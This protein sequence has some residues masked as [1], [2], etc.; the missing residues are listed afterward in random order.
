M[1]VSGPVKGYFIATIARCGD[2]GCTARGK[3]C[4]TRPATFED[5]DVLFE[6]G[7]DEPMASAD[8][9]HLSAF[10]IAKKSLEDILT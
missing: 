3:V 6:V 8:E 5:A 7:A 2:A 1:R 9:A 10:R 4:R